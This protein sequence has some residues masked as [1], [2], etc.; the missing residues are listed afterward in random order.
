MTA[1]PM[2]VARMADLE[3]EAGDYAWITARLVDLAERHAR[4]RLVSTL[5]GG[6]SL[7]ALRECVAAHVGVLLDG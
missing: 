1:Q 6:Y 2:A 3:L 5:E 7:T 4:G